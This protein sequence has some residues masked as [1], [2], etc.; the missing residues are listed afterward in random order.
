MKKTKD[1]NKIRAW[2]DCPTCKGKGRTIELLGG[3]PA[4]EGPCQTC[5]AFFTVLDSIFKLVKAKPNN[6]T[7]QSC[8]VCYGGSSFPGPMEEA[9]ECHGEILATD[10]WKLVMMP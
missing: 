3:V 6:Y 9:L 5:A 8:C 7:L 2:K 10:I 1:E 4:L